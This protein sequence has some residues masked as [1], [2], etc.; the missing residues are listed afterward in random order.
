MSACRETPLRLAKSRLAAVARLHGAC[1]RTSQAPWACQLSFAFSGCTPPFGWLHLLNLS[2]ALFSLRG[3]PP[4][5]G[6]AREL[7][8]F[9]S[10]GR[11]NGGMLCY[12][13]ISSSHSTHQGN[14]VRFRDDVP[15]SSS[16]FTL[17]C[18]PFNVQRRIRN[19]PGWECTNSPF[20]I[21]ILCTARLSREGE[22]W[23]IPD[24]EN[25][26]FLAMSARMSDLI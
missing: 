15:Q 21:G 2:V 8:R 14:P 3:A 26:F 24:G 5:E 16:T 19:I 1:G 17:R 13:P 18:V 11:L 23:D 4:P 10:R 22:V 7:G 12:L 6:A 9:I 25:H 20:L